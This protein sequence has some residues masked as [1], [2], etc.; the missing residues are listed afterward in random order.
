[1]PGLFGTRREQEP[2]Q[3]FV[4]FQLQ[5]LEHE[6]SPSGSQISLPLFGKKDKGEHIEHGQGSPFVGSPLRG[7]TPIAGQGGSRGHARQ[8]T[9]EEGDEATEDEEQQ[10]R[11]KLDFRARMFILFVACTFSI[12]SHFAQTLGPLLPLLKSRLGI[13]DRT[14]T[15]LLSSQTLL[16]TV[17]PLLAGLLVARHGTLRSSLFATSTLFIG[18]FIA[19]FGVLMS[20]IG[21]LVTGLVVFGMGVSPLAL[22]QETLLVQVFGAHERAGLALAVG[23]VAGKGTSF[24]AAETISSMTKSHAGL[25]TPFAVGTALTALGVGM[26]ITWIVW[27]IRR[28][29]A[30]EERLRI[31][32]FGARGFTP[33]HAEKED[34]VRLSVTERVYAL[35]GLFYLYLG[36]AVGVGCVWLP[37]VN[38]STE[39]LVERYGMTSDKAAGWAG[40][41]LALPILLYPAAGWVTDRYG[42]RLT[43]LLVSTLF[44]L[45][46]YSLLLAKSLPGS[47][48]LALVTFA[49]GYGAGPLLM[50]VTAQRLVGAES[51][52]IALGGW[53]MLEMMG[54]TLTQ[55]WSG[56]LLD[57]EKEFDIQP[58]NAVLAI[59][60]ACNF[61]VAGLV[62]ILLVLDKHQ[63]GGYLNASTP[64][65][66]GPPIPS[67]SRYAQLPQ[68][69]NE[70][71][72]AY[73]DRI[74]R[75][76][77]E[78]KVVTLSEEEVRGRRRARWCGGVLAVG[79]VVVWGSYVWVLV[80]ELS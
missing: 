32:A 53:K 73:V 17:I 47:A 71:D 43:L 24:I 36:V 57:Q 52:S 15:S 27:S 22:I 38:L 54:T 3:H 70:D 72:E 35:P 7:G 46:S 42:H 1:M 78:G 62:A 16:N 61:V 8:V 19:L 21:W 44:T 26:N 29:R 41:V 69:E 79:G 59:L 18:E 65:S 25:T 31:Q 14:L 11:D 48:T 76:R 4:G 80:D 68:M 12:G 5:P 55:T 66:T 10:P 2:R 75:E 67:N 60:W 30:E 50:V 63:M 39:V 28:S 56:I 40:W 6:A 20:K 9:G 49:I 13:P 23:L 37:F 58:F 45:A 74:E 34:V 51:V 64:S 33:I 77:R